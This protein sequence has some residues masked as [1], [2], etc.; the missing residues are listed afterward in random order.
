MFW[1][2][3]ACFGTGCGVVNL[4]I[5]NV[6]TPNVHTPKPTESNM[7]L[8]VFCDPRPLPPDCECCVL[9]AKVCVHGG[10]ALS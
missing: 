2:W 7:P 8:S 6:H 10:F 5:H 1:F 4:G 9:S 3:V